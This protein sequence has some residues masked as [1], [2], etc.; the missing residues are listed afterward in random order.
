MNE[1]PDCRI[2]I[3][4]FEWFGYNLK[5]TLY[6]SEAPLWKHLFWYQ[7]FGS[8]LIHVSQYNDTFTK[9]LEIE[10]WSTLPTSKYCKYVVNLKCLVKEEM[11][12]MQM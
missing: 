6:L 10:T 2:I 11:T 4:I 9:N 3:N 7:T 1:N 8:V 12:T 5:I